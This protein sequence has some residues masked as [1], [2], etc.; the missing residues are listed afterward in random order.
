[1]LNYYYIIMNIFIIKVAPLIEGIE[2]NNIIFKNSQD[3]YNIDMK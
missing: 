1:M 3:R 2:G